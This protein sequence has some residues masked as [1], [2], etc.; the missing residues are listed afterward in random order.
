MTDEVTF[1]YIK[2]NYFRVAHADGAWGGIT[3][4]GLIQI[5][6]YSERQPIA[7]QTFHT[8][9][10]D[11]LG[12]E[13]ADRRIVRDGPVREIEF[14]AVMDLSTAKLVREWL[15]DKIKVLEQEFGNNGKAK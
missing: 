14:G 13:I 10:G 3:P 11:R 2:S 8:I 1:H 12:P 9:E 6:F 5:N 15:D 4:R 7:K